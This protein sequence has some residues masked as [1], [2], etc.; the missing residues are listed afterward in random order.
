MSLAGVLDTRS[1]HK[2]HLYFY[3]PGTNKQKAEWREQLQSQLHQKR[4]GSPSKGSAGFGRWKQ[5]RRWE[6]VGDSRRGREC[7]MTVGWKTQDCPSPWSALKSVKSCKDLSKNLGGV[8]IGKLTIKFTWK[9]KTICKTI[10]RNKKPGAFMW[11]DVGFC[12]EASLTAAGP[13]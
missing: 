4:V 2:N 6:K 10:L 5:E 7:S 3:Q 11:P 8:E 13:G 12:S 9:C 1:T